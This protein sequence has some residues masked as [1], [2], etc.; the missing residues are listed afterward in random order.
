MLQASPEVD[1]VHRTIAIGRCL[2][3]V[4]FRSGAVFPL[5]ERHSADEDDSY[6][7]VRSILVSVWLKKTTTQYIGRGWK[8]DDPEIWLTRPPSDKIHSR[9]SKATFSHPE[10][11]K[12]Y[13]IILI[14]H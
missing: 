8:A 1:F 14:M 6:T 4:V 5:E 2:V 9:L 10:M 3:G 13:L 11:T 12:G 7:N